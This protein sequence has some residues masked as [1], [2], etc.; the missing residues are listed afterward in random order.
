ML[1]EGAGKKRVDDLCFYN[2]RNFLLLLAEAEGGGTENEEKENKKKILHVC[3]GMYH[4]SSKRQSKKHDFGIL[5][6]AQ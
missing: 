2:M 6:C 4:H 1:R 5:S 3:E